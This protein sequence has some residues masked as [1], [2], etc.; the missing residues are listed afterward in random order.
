MYQTPD[1]KVIN[2]DTESA[3]MDYTGGD[4]NSSPDWMIED[5]AESDWD[6]MP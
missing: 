4:V 5:F 3:I 1:V 2:F 6:V